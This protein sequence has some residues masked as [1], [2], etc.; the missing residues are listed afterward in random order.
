MLTEQEIR[1]LVEEQVKAFNNQDLDRFLSYRTPDVVIEDTSIPEPMKG[2]TAVG[3]WFSSWWS[4]FP[5]AKVTLEDVV[6]SGDAAVL[7]LR[8]TGTHRGEMMTPFGS[9]SPTGRRVEVRG[10]HVERFVGDKV[11]RDIVYVPHLDLLRQLGALS[12]LAKAA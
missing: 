2:K 8:F 5:D 3:Q 11:Q 4:A 10:C 12:L 9:V 7:Q 6:V 1:K